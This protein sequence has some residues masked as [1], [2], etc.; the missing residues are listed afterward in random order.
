MSVH[1]EALDALAAWLPP[2]D[3]PDRPQIQV[4]TV[5]ATGRPDIRTVLLSEWDADGFVFHTDARSRKAE[6]L[7]DHAAVAIDVLW[8]GFTR[9]IV[10]RGTAEVADRERLDRA[11]A[12]RS[13]YLKQL[14]H[15]N[16]TEFA[17]HERAERVRL[18]SAFGRKQD[19]ALLTPPDTWTGYLVRPD[20]LTFW[21]SD[22]DGPSHRT[23]YRLEPDGS[24][25]S[26]HL[27]G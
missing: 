26:H 17:Q 2:N 6:Q 21:E 5:D 11:F 19:L 1:G 9:Q 23:E 16:T 25:S 18:W 24:W 20:R 14:A 12:L 22:P 15:Q 3:D 10:V 7:A 8:P 13:A 4:A 27:A